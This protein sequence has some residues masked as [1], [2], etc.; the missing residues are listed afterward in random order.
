[1]LGQL[2]ARLFQ[3]TGA[4][5]PHGRDSASVA[6]PANPLAEYF[7]N[8]PGRMINKWH[9]YLEIYH[10]HFAAF[11]DQSPVVVEIGVWQ[12][13]SLQMWREYFGPGCRI[14]G[15][16]NNPRCR[17]FAD[18]HTMILIGDQG[19]REFLA[20]V[21]SR[22]PKIDILIDDGGHTMGQQIAT[23]EELYPHIQRHGIY[24]CEDVHTSLLNPF[25]GG[26]RREGTFLEYSKALVD[27][28]YGWYSQ[29]QKLLGITDFTESTFGLHFYDSVVVIE[30]RPIKFPVKSCTGTPSF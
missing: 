8:N 13:G 16:D 26:V 12:G 27:R 18:E 14:V 3:S 5:A 25:G 19:D 7:F 30:K 4:R 9:H 22:V 24:L 20:S 21:R 2:I 28:L 23:F 11:R 6:A 1:M 15:I 10:R 17:K 29:E